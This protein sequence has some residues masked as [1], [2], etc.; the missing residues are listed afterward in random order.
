[1]LL[2]FAA[3]RLR[4]GHITGTGPKRVLALRPRPL[5]KDQFQCALLR[6][7]D[8]PPLLQR[9]ASLRS[10][11]RKRGAAIVPLVGA[12]RSFQADDGNVALAFVT[13]SSS[14]QQLPLF[15][16]LLDRTS[17]GLTLSNAATFKRTGIFQTLTGALEALAKAEG[18]VFVNENAAA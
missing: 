9:S 1:M 16:F 8:R 13:P 5:F 12:W 18:V 17:K 3:D 11:R 14:R 7:H 10:L 6:R 2:M 4:S 15:A